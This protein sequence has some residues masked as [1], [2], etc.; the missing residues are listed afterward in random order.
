VKLAMVGGGGFRT[1]LVHGALLGDRHDRRVDEVALHD[2]DSDRLAAMSAVLAQQAAARSDA[3]APIRVNATTDL[4]RALEGADFVFTAQR[5]GGVAARVVDERVALAC[6]V[7]GQETTGPGGLAFGLR[8]V[9]AALHVARRVAALAPQAWVINF[10]NPAG[11]ITESMQAVLGDRV[12]GICDS[13][14]ALA[15][16][17]ARALGHDP[18]RATPRYLGLTHLGWLLGLDV[19]G[20]DVLPDLLARPDLLAGTEEGRLFGPEWVGSLGALP[21]E[22]LYYYYYTREAI[23]GI[24]RAGQTRGEYLRDQQGAFYRE[25]AR[26]PERA[27][28]RW[29]EAR[30]ERDATYLAEAR[31]EGEPR[32]PLDVAGGGYEGVA[33]AVMAAVARDEPCELILNVRGAGRAIPGL[34]PDAVV[35]ALCRVDGSGAAALPAPSL[36]GAM[37]GLVQQVKAVEQLIVAAAV[38]GDPDLAVQAFALHPLVDSVSVARQLLRGYRQGIPEVDAVFG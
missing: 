32:D 10:T 25:V 7:L 36:A 21:N 14:V 28:R 12:V 11:M 33:L 34:P 29:L 5:V 20:R 2:V 22:Y 4:D 37:L 16:R 38:R 8:T 26:R 17:A 13:P 9:P 23:A 31:D 3:G 19:E 1:P 15:R 18:G 35:E 30:A 6:G 24:G 27:Y